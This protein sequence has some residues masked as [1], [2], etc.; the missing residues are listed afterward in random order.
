IGAAKLVWLAIALPVDLVRLKMKAA[1]IGMEKTQYG[2]LALRG[3]VLQV[4]CLYEHGAEATQ[5]NQY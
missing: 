4:M 1:V 2:G 3:G 5:E